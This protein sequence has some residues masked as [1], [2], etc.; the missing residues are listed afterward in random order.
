MARCKD[1]VLHRFHSDSARDL[2][3]AELQARKKR[4]DE[5]WASFGDAL[6]VLADKAYPELEGKASH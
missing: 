4:N 6:R 1:E 3:M 2:Y 5:D